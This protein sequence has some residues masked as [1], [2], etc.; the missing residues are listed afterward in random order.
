MKKKLY[1]SVFNNKKLDIQNRNSMNYCNRNSSNE[2][3][4][5]YN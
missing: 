2:L 1:D 5:E 3:Y 4:T